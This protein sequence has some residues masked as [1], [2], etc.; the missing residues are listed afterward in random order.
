[1]T[2]LRRQF[3]RFD[4][5]EYPWP[6]FAHLGEQEVKRKEVHWWAGAPAGE[7]EETFGYQSRYAECK[8]IPSTVHGDFRTNM[9]HYH[10][11]RKFPDSYQAQL[12]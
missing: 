2:M 11:A 1:M 5:L 9:L 3:Q 8:H 6:E 4:K 10:M 12:N 7:G